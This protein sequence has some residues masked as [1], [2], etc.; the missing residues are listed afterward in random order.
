MKK[1]SVIPDPE[2]LTTKRKLSYRK[3]TKTDREQLRCGRN[4][5]GIKKARKPGLFYMYVWL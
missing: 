2:D 5:S 3:V 1:S 4:R